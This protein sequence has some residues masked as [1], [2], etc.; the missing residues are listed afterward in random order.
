[1]IFP[2]N[3]SYTLNSQ[4]LPGDNGTQ[5]TSSQA[6]ENRK[7]SMEPIM[8]LATLTLFLPACFALNMAPMSEQ[9]PLG[10]HLDAY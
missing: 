8:D 4:E 1:M 2:F 3:I 6:P 5:G 9:S 7:T 10:Q